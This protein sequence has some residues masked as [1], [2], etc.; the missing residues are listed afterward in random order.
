MKI[1][2]ALLVDPDRN[3]AYGLAATAISIFVFA[4]SARFGQLPIL[5]YYALW[6]PLL[7]VDYRRVLGNYTRF[8][9]IVGF[10]GIACLSVFWSAAPGTTARAAAQYSSHVICA[11]IAARTI[12]TTT[13]A[14]GVIAGTALVV[15]YSLAVGQYHYDP[16]DGDYSFVGAFSSKNYLGFFA[17]IG[18][19]FAY[20]AVF[21]LRERGWWR[22]FAVADALLCAYALVASRSATSIVALA[23]TLFAMLGLAVVLSFAP[24]IRKIFLL[25]LLVLSLAAAFAAL[26]AGGLDLLLGAFGKDSTLTGRTYLWEEGFAAAQEAPF[27]GWGYQAYWV[28]GFPEAERL[29]QEFYI[30]SRAGFHFHNTYIETLVELGLAGLVLLILLI[31]RVVAGHLRRLLD[32]HR[33]K[34]SHVAFGVGTMLLVRSFFEVDVIHPYAVGSF[35]LVYCAGLLARPRLQMQAAK[36]TIRQASDARFA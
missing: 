33:E 36:Q 12:G 25:A 14:R 27:F 34:A 21:V 3:A 6:L 30:G 23:V 9:W 26:S 29:W 17:S 1:A 15:L 24:R 22:L 5:V 35:L 19:F 20:A 13:L 10:A 18:L 8:L 32:D 31:V 4:Y 11:L 2:K 7:L 28:Q 16:V